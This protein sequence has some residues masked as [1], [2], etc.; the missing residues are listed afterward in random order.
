MDAK[1][2]MTEAEFLKAITDRCDELGLLW[3]HSYDSRRDRMAGFPDLVVVGHGLLFRELKSEDGSVSAGQM[4]FGRA[5]RGAGGN[6]A[7]W[8]PSD[9]S[10]GLLQGE[11]RM[12]AECPRQLAS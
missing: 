5:I 2:V 11:L 7:V 9:W 12:L 3:F 1:Q 6:W 10:M 8:R 4:A